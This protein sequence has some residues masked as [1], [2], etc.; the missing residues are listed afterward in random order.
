MKR[1]MKLVE[2]RLPMELVNRTKRVAKLAGVTPTQAYNVILAVAVLD[3]PGH[4]SSHAA[5]G[6]NKEET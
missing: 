6:R 5:G 1:K 4:P 2:L 3:H